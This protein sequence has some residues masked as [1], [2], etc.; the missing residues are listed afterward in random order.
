ARVLHRAHDLDAP[1]LR[2]GALVAQA[3]EGNPYF[4]LVAPLGH[5]AARFVDVVGV[6]VDGRVESS[7]GAR[8]P[9]G[10]RGDAVAPD[11]VFLY[12]ERIHREH[13]GTA[14]IEVGVEQDGDVVV[15]VDVV[16]VGE[17]GAHRVA[18]ALERADAEVD[19]VGRVPHQHL[20]RILGGAPVHGAVLRESREAGGPAPHRLV[21]HAVD[22]HLGLEARD[23]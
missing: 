6:Q 9:G 21:Q 2:V 11:A 18:V 10:A 14:V 5:A 1:I 12:A 8:A 7:A 15:G 20:G 16:A 13:R 17:G 3:L 19:R 4:H 22:L 23:A